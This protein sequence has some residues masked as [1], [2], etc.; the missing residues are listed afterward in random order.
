MNPKI[1]F[2]L[3]RIDAT[4]YSDF[5]NLLKRSSFNEDAVLE[6]VNAEDF[7]KI[8][9]EALPIYHCMLAE[10]TPLNCL[11]KLFILNLSVKNGV[12][13]HVFGDLFE[14]LV[15]IGV[16]KEGAHHVTSEVDIYPCMGYFF[17]TDHRL[18]C[19]VGS[20]RVYYLGKDSYALARGIVRN[21]SENSLDLC[22][23]SGVHGILASSFSKR[24]ICAEINPRALNFINFNIR[25]NQVTNVIALASDLYLSLP[26]QKFDLILSN[27]PFI[28][29][30][31]FNPYFD[32]SISGEKIL[33][34]IISGLPDFLS[35]NG[36]CQI[37]TLVIHAKEHYAQE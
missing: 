18:N 9:A 33:K 30:P 27:P 19:N 29:D 20:L 36:L 10:N 31:T 34:R 23:G 5:Y 14:L 16:L 2:D 21:P 6:S 32:S 26:A 35:V 11:I 4:F 7:D 22:A 15:C 37:F 12:A 17:S 24:V 3:S 13:K 1:P 25:L 28:P 8:H